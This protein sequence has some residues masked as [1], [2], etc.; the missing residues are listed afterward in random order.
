[1]LNGI[2]EPLLIAL[3][4]FG[5]GALLGLAARLGRFCTLGAIE[6]YLYQQSDTRLRMWVLAI[7]VAGLL[8]F[9]LAG[10]GAVNLSANVY[11]L[12]PWSPLITVLGGLLFGYGMSLAGNCGFGALARF[13]GGDLRSFVIVI[14]MGIAAYVMMSGP[15]AR[16]RQMVTEATTP[17][18]D[19]TNYAALLSQMTGLPL[20]WAGGALSLL[21]TLLALGSSSFLR[22]RE[23]LFWG[24]IVGVA[25]TSG[26]VGTTWVATHGFTP[27]PVQSHTFS[28]PLGETILFLM[29]ASGGGL[30][31]GVGSVF[32]VLAGAFCGSLI[33]GH[34]RWE[35]CEDPRELRRQILGAVCMGF[36]AVLA[37]GCTIGQ[38]VSA[39][40]VLAL[41]APITFIAIFIGAAIGLRQLITGF[42]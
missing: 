23:A 33:K 38:G 11:Y 25:V 15:L 29:T 5:G 17:A 32:G 34:F 21:I 9:G 36:G 3:I 4:G 16:L 6:D 31:F 10:V 37:F 26:W 42:A 28:A 35:A 30:S 39:F 13:G 22:D 27:Q 8:T 19:T 7:G 12:T 20:V 14:V 2:P 18:L 24:T 1:M 41:S 40:S